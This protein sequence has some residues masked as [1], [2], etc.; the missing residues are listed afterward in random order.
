MMGNSCLP[1]YNYEPV[2]VSSSTTCQAP[3]YDEH[4]SRLTA[5]GGFFRSAAQGPDRNLIEAEFTAGVFRIYFNGSLVES[6]SQTSGVG[7]F[8][9]LRSKL[10]SST[11]IEMPALGYDVYDTRI[12]E[13]DSLLGGGMSYFTRTSFTGGSGGPT[14][15]TGLASIR[16]GPT[17]TIFV[18]RTTESD[19]GMSVDPPSYRKVQQWNGESWV[20]Y[21]NTV[22]GNCPV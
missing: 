19:T 1:S 6:Y 4:R 22:P 16:T 20:T 12:A 15:S 8:A 18:L 10:A 7:S 3:G 5:G 2:F 13:D 9:G 21:S 17:R 11:Y 14:D